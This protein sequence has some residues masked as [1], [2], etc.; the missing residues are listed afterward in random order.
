M[1]KCIKT[2]VY[3]NHTI[4]SNS[5]EQA[6]DV[7]F[8]LPDFCPD[9][10]KIFKCKAVPRILSKG[11]NGKTLTLEG[12]VCITVLYSDSEGKIYSYEYQ[13]PFQKNTELSDGAEGA[14]IKCSVN[15]D[16]I[17]CRAVSGRKIDI[18]GAVSIFVKIF[19]RKSCEILSD[20]DY[21]SLELKKGVTP[22]TVPMGYAEKYLIL[23]DVM[24]INCPAENLHNILR[25]EATPCIKESKIVNEKVVLKGEMSVCVLYT[26][27]NCVVH[28]A[29]TVIPF[30]QIIDLT[31][32][33]DAC[34]LDT[35]CELAFLEIKPNPASNENAVL[36]L[37]A[38]ILFM[39]EAFCPNDIAVVFDAFSRKYKAD[40]SRENMKFTRVTQN[41]SETFT[42]K[43][44]VELTESIS[45]VVDL[46][47]EIT[48]KN[49]RFENDCIKFMGS[50]TVG[51]IALTAND[52]ICYFDG[53]I[54]FAHSINSNNTS[55]FSEAIPQIEVI[56]C[57]YTFLTDTR[58][59]ICAQLQLN[60]A[61][62]ENK[63]IAL[64]TD[65]SIDEK[66]I[67][68]K[69]CKTALNLHFATEKQ[70]LWE[71]A[72][73]YNASVEELAEL[74]G[75]IDGEIPVGKILL[76]PML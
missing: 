27:F 45:S 67:T 25:Y 32:V 8:T 35:K 54:P 21:Q 49:T 19:K 68:C 24:P 71:I 60:A 57:N 33:N 61:V 16:Y 44:T 43:N 76:V 18:H 2:N 3:S 69:K 11:V 66:Q 15:L 26:D 10:S 72:Q 12:S 37:N 62:V 22:A 53:E 7:D 29:K 28:N 74:N 9:I 63:E 20:F 47:C 31:G 39:C 13:Y 1:E 59:E 4:F 52:E 56:S 58:I 48:S 64:I 30:S 46:S 6:I 38:K 23:E 65:I 17:H 40:I 34:E 73:M 5:L 75:L 41:I 55:E 42:C 70:E 50:V 51:I 36:N 14:N